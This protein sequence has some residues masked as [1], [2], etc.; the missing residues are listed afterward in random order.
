MNPTSLQILFL[1]LI[2]SCGC[3]S[4]IPG[5]YFDHFFL[6]IFENQGYSD[7]TQNSDFMNFAN[8]GRLLTQFYA[9]Q[10]PSQPN[11]IT[12]LAADHMGVNDDNV[13]DIDGTNLVDLLEQK[14]V[15]WKSYN[16]DYPGNC[17][18]GSKKGKYARKHTPFI[19]FTDISGNK[20]RCAKIVE[21]KELDNDLNNLQNLPQF[22]FFTPNLN[23]DGHDTDLETA[24]AFLSSF[25][26]S[27]LQ[28]FPAK[29]LVV[30]TWDEG[31]GSDWD[32]NHIYT[33][34]VGS[35]VPKGTKDG[36]KYGMPSFT[37]LIEENWGLGS[38]GREDT[39]ANIMFPIQ[40]QFE[41]TFLAK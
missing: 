30:V 6:I 27:R 18:T 24:G 40:N 21:G 22:M 31:E 15:S 10:H 17:Y 14:G 36:Q 13:H 34:M 7:V 9:E 2:L 29:T 39:K 41:E 12:I 23:D 28:K 3:S 19:S 26:K 1:S 38:L 35:M 11:Y 25:F 5:K 8:Q 4:L 16:E 33:A 32:S 37:R 20:Q